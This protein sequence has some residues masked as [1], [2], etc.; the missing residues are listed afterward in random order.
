MDH[1]TRRLCGLFAGEHADNPFFII[2]FPVL[3]LG[4]GR[5]LWQVEKRWKRSRFRYCG[6]RLPLRDVENLRPL[7]AVQRHK[8]QGG[9]GRAEIDTDAEMGSRHGRGLRLATPS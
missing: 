7:V 4:C 5:F 9:V 2:D 3:E 1:A 8:T 6:Q